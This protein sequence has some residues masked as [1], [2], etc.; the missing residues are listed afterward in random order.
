MNYYNEFDPFAAAWLRNL[1]AARHLPPGEVDER[2]IVD[3]RPGDLR[4]FRQC[5][6]FAG[7]G[8]WPYALRLA[9]WPDERPVWTG[10]CP[11]QPISSAGKRR[12]HA[13]ERH[14]WPAFHALIA[15]CRP[16]TV[17][18]EQVASA[19]GREWFAG[20]RADLEA[21]GY[22]CGAADLCAAGCGAPHIRQRLFWLA[23]RDGGRQPKLAQ[24][25]GEQVAGIEASRRHDVVGCGDSGRLADDALGRR[26]QG[27]RL[28]GEPER[29][30][31]G[32]ADDG[33]T[34]RLGDADQPGLEGRDIRTPGREREAVERAGALLGHW[35]DFDLIPCTDGKARRTQSAVQWMVDGISHCLVSLR[36][37][38]KQKVID[39]ATR[40]G[41]G[42]E[43]LRALRGGVDPEEV[44]GSLGRCLGVPQATVLLACLCQHAGELGRILNSQAPRIEAACQSGVRTVWQHETAARP[45]HGW[46]PS[47]QHAE[48][49]GD[50]LRLL[51]SAT[52]QINGTIGALECFDTL[53]L[54]QSAS[55]RVGRLRAYG[56]AIV[57]QVAAEFIQAFLEC[58]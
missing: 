27:L 50:A 15:E 38:E 41:L 37:D 8:G 47:Q 18:G 34:G 33:A 43:T 22:A 23:D 46:E 58:R 45:S 14:L 3:V 48:Q 7:I 2:S 20:V 40:S 26:G 49:F 28:D 25:D 44:W 21:L 35:S 57:P 55:G 19:D 30:G 5:H 17:F 29:A 24:C 42:A 36:S 32:L 39:A 16:A 11:C 1:I 10:S 12:G 4:G 56:N 31:D 13:D 52:P 54:K 51:S 6:F 53:P 9:G